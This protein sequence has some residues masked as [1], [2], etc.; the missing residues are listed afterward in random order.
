VRFPRCRPTP[1]LCAARQG[2]SRDPSEK[3][4]SGFMAWEKL[5]LNKYPLFLWN[6]SVTGVSRFYMLNLAPEDPPARHFLPG[7]RSPLPPSTPAR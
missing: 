6:S 4:G 1:R 5:M 7:P 2:P 3:S